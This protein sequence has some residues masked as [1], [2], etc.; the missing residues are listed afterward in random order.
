MY[1]FDAELLAYERHSALLREAE[2]RRLAGE[3]LM[4]ARRA[5][6]AAQAA[7]LAEEAATYRA[8]MAARPVAPS[9]W[10]RLARV[11]RPVRPAA[12]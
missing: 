1:G 12:I 10:A 7:R 6:R 8:V 5:D 9:L 11:F 4:H 2:Q 3:V